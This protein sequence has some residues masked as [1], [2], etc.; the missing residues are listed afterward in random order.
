MSANHSRHIAL[1]ETLS[2]WVDLQV[3]TGEYSSASDLIPTATRRVRSSD[4]EVAAVLPASSM[5]PSSRQRLV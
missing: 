3:T 5:L 4:G 2:A 1:T